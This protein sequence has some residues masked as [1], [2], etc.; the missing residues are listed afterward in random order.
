MLVR[1]VMTMVVVAGRDGG[2]CGEELPNGDEI[3]LQ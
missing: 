1:M 3:N 2:D